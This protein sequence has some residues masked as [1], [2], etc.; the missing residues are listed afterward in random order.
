MMGTCQV[1]ATWAA[2]ADAPEQPAPIIALTPA[3][4]STLRV[5][6][7]VAVSA[8]EASHFESTY[9][10][11]SCVLGSKLSATPSCLLLTSRSA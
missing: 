3:P 6:S 8:C 7:S 5:R 11:C 4:S 1:P 10:K 9:D 2:M